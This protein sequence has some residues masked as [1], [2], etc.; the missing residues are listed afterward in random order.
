MPP[1]FAQKIRRNDGDFEAE[2]IMQQ[3]NQSDT[4]VSDE[5]TEYD[6]LSGLRLNS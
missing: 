6:P 1:L 5:T 4:R 3:V 2:G